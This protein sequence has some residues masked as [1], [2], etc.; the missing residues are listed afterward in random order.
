MIH[1]LRI[2]LAGARYSVVRAMMFRGDFIMWGMVE[3]FW[4]AVNIAAIAV[5]YEHTDSVAGWSK[6]EMLLLLGTSMLVQRMVMGFFWSNLFELGRNIR[7]GH[8]DFF[9]AQPGSPLFM[10]STRKI[11][12]DSILNIF[13]SLAIVIY[14]AR[15]L[16]LHPSPSALVMYAVFVLCG[17][18]L[19]YSI[20]LI[21]VS[22][23]FW[24]IGSQGM[25]SG[26]FTLAEFSRLPKEAFSGVTNVIFVW[27]LPSVVISNAPARALISGF[28]LGYTGWMLGATL[29]WFLIATTVFH[30]G[31]RRYA[32]ASS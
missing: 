4:M 12:L 26:Y 16:G 29:V 11:D 17:L 3:L 18:I 6:F 15:E 19:S 8:F 20:L 28:D 9:L 2:W 13:V 25:E 5:I 24:T 32:S 14:A 10:V 22:I 21:I 31:L 23:S 7:S 1:Y 30:R 27:I